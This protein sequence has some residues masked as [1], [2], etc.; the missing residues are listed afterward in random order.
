MQNK[1]LLI[2]ALLGVIL[3]CAGTQLA[4]VHTVDAQVEPGQ[5]RECVAYVL[6]A[7]TN[8][9][10]LPAK[11]KSIAGWTPVGGGGENYPT[12]VLCR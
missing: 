10:D 2:A 6:D 3:G 7:D 11:A 4:Q 1:H 8:L 12:V 5:F 9:E